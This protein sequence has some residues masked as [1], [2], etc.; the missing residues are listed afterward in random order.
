MEWLVVTRTVKPK[1]TDYS[2]QSEASSSH[3]AQSLSGLAFRRAAWPHN[4]IPQSRSHASRPKHLTTGRP[5]STPPS[6]TRYFTS[7]PNMT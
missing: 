6:A 3:E 2:E 5:N 1:Q 7:L 4:S